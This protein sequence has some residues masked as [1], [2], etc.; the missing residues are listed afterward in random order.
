M[1]KKKIR[2]KSQLSSQREEMSNPRL[3]TEISGASAIMFQRSNSF[4][5]FNGKEQRSQIKSFVRCNEEN[6]RS[7]GS[8]QVGEPL[9]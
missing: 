7:I 8:S 9:L 5:D 6:T 2:K 3:G 1:I 4:L